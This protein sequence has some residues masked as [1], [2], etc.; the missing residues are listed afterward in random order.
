MA[1]AARDFITGLDFILGLAQSGGGIDCA[2]VNNVLKNATIQAQR[3]NHS[4]SHLEG[5]MR[6]VQEFCEATRR[7]CLLLV[8]NC[9][10][11]VLAEILNSTPA[12]SE[13]NFAYSYKGVHVCS[14]AEL[15][16]LGANLEHFDCLIPKTI[17]LRTSA[18]CVPTW[19]G[20]PTPADS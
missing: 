20:A 13:R 18:A 12:F 3:R 2:L 9:Q 5:Q 17:F 8:G 10:T 16:Q 19:C 15:E 11:P 4:Q 14:L 6:I 7:R 1:I